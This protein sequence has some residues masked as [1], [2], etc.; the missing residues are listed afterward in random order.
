MIRFF[1]KSRVLAA[2]V[3]SLSPVSVATAQDGSI[4]P[5]PLAGQQEGVPN[6]LESPFG[7]DGEMTGERL[8]ILAQRVDPNAQVAGNGYI[9]KIQ[10]RDLRI[11]FDENA[12]RM[13]IITP[14]IPATNLPDGLLLRLSQANFD[15]A[16]DA[17]YAI[18]SG[19][20]WASFVHRLS[21]LTD[22]D[23]ISGLAQTAVA[24]ETFG[25]TFS[26]GAFVFGGGDSAEINQDL[27]ERLQKAIEDG[28][29]ARGI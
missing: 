12:D 18:G 6:Q 13:R 16:L 24:A 27:L 9:L 3:L 5:P 4:A 17:R 23:F 10:D 20:V 22:E 8:G 29:D 1:S 15:S 21:S 28:E 25:T 26:S 14:I 11:V 19:M 7:F 2:L